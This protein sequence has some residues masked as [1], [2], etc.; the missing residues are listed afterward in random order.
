[1]AFT[2]RGRTAKRMSTQDGLGSPS[3]VRTRNGWSLLETLVT[4]SIVLVAVALL[5]SGALVLRE[6][7]RQLTCVQRLSK[8]YERTEA[9]R[10]DN[11]DHWPL[12][13]EGDLGWPQLVFKELPK[14]AEGTVDPEGRI[15]ELLCP[16]D[17]ARTRQEGGLSYVFN[18]GFGDFPVSAEGVHERVPHQVAL[19]I[20][21]DGKVTPNEEEI[22]FATG[23]VWRPH[24]LRMTGAMIEEG[25]GQE[26]TLL[27]TENLSA[28][29][30][31]SR[32]TA[33]LAF[34]LGRGQL[35]FTKSPTGPEALSLVPFDLGPFRPSSQQPARPGLS[36]APS[37]WHDGVV[38]ALY[39]SGSVR[40]LNVTI[41]PKV[42]AGLM[43]PLGGKYGEHGA[44][45][46]G[47]P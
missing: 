39:S 43:T 25:D 23:V 27:A 30:W 19:D 41:D 16:A 1:M 20:D 42:Y 21:G 33:D 35:R 46:D 5:S 26:W 31:A 37:S 9:Y 11:G 18:G 34:V 12:L 15:P 6:K 29:R 47:T 10:S 2:G 44:A 14:T 4:V 8:V 36:P 38:N 22:N 40:P 45:T 3:S 24:R 17:F 7:S 28:R 32:E 13:E